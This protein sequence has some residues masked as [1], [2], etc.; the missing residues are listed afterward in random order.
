MTTYRLV[1]L[2]S[3]SVALYRDDEEMWTISGGNPQTARSTLGAVHMA[4]KKT[5]TAIYGRPELVPD[6]HETDMEWTTP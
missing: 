6:L 3:H 1:N 5:L 2:G 4:A